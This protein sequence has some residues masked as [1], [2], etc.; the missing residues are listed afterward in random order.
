MLK[1]KMENEVKT[2][3]S[4]LLKEASELLSNSSETST[5]R[6]EPSTSRSTSST[7]EETLKRASSMLRESSS[8]GLCRRLNRPERLRAASGGNYDRTKQ[9]REKP[10][11][12]KKALEFALLRCLDEEDG[13][14][15]HLKWDSVIASG[16]LMLVEDDDEREIRRKIVESLQEKY[17]LLGEN[18]FDFVKVRH[19]S[20]S[21]LQLGRGTEYNYPVVKKMAG[22][23]LLYLKVKDAYRFVYDSE[24]EDDEVFSK[25]AFEYEK[26]LDKEPNIS[27]ED[28]TKTA[29]NEEEEEVQEIPAPQ[30]PNSDSAPALRSENEN[31]P[32]PWDPLV[33]TMIEQRLADPVE[34]LRFLQ[35]ELVKGR[36]IDAVSESDSHDGVTN[37]ICVD[38]HN[39]LET[40]FSELSSVESFDL[41]FEVDFMGEKARD[42]GG[43]RKEWI[44]LVNNAIKEKY[45]DS[46]LRVHLAD[47]YY[48]VGIMIAV[49]LLQN[50][51]LPTY[52]PSDVIEQLAT[53]SS[54]E[55]IANI[56]RGLNTCGMSHIFQC[57]PIVL[58][59]L[60]PSKKKLTPKILLHL[61]TPEFSEEGS[62]AVIREKEVYA[63]FIKYVRETGSGRR[64]PV[65]L[66]SILIFVTGASEEP[67][68][69]FVIPPCIRFIK[70]RKIVLCKTVQM[71]SESQHSKRAFIFR[72]GLGESG[73]H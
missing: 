65:T 41:T 4:K 48:F 68:L 55:C 15:Q 35:K 64:A 21:T 40:T 29:E 27:T 42:L 57:F 69:G 63:L 47:D 58:Q 24:P 31:E 60:Q 33:N 54:N 52:M 6:T 13:E 8:S 70:V 71:N 44:R 28:N 7:I 50:G 9:A 39:I 46:G 10:K 36:A 23:G 20:I 1:R 67:V 32:S 49:A 59:L 72:R 18:N 66:E 19:K 5:Q 3:V 56:Q 30:K 38:R 11:K 16:M 12:E 61:L 51:Q 34:I 62:T 45:F 73:S 26:S 37:S 17:P 53:P 43:P 2:K 14:S 25:S 22:Q